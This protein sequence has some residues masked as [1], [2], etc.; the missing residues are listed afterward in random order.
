MFFTHLGCNYPFLQRERFMRDLEEKQVDSILVDAVCGVAARFSSDPMLTTAADDD[1]TPRE[2][3]SKD[4]QRAFR[5]HAYT[6]RAMSAIIDTFPCP[7]LAVAQACLLL[8]YEEFGTDHDSGLWM[9]L[10]TSIR[11]AQ[12]LGIQK[13]EGLQLQGRIGPTPK[14]V[15]SDQN[16][17]EE[18]YR[19]AEQQKSLSEDHALAGTKELEDRRASE[20]ERIDTFWA[21]FFL[22]RAVSSGVGRPVTLR[23]KDIEISFP[24]EPDETTIN[25]FPHPFPPM[26]RIVHMYGR[27]AD[28]LNH[29]KDLSQVTP[30]VLKKLAK[31]E[32]DLTT[33][34]QRLSPKLHFNATNFQHYVKAEQELSISSAKTIADILAFAEL[35]DVKSF[36]GNPFT[37]QPIEAERYA[38]PMHQT[39]ASPPLSPLDLQDLT[40]DE[41]TLPS[42]ASAAM[43][44][45]YDAELYAALLPD[46]YRER[47]NTLQDK[48]ADPEMKTRGILISHP[49][50]DYELL[51]ERLLESLELDA[52]R[53][54]N[55]HFLH[56]DRSVGD[57]GFES[58]SQEGDES[59]DESWK[60]GRCPDCGKCLHLQPEDAR[61]WEIKVYAANGLMRAGA[62]AA[63]W[64]DMEKVDVEISLAMPD[65]V[66]R[67]INSRLEILRSVQDG[68][69]GLSATSH[70]ENEINDEAN[71]DNHHSYEHTNPPPGPTEESGKSPGLGR[72]TD[73]FL[74]RKNLLIALL[75]ILVVFYA[76]T[77]SRSATSLAVPL[78]MTEPAARP[79]EPDIIT[80]TLV[81]NSVKPD[82]QGPVPAVVR[83]LPSTTTPLNSGNTGGAHGIQPREKTRAENGLQSEELDEELPEVPE[84]LSKE[85]EELAEELASEELPE[86]LPE[87]PE[88]PQSEGLLSEELPEEPQSERLLS[89]ELQQE[90]LRSES[91]HDN[92]SPLEKEKGTP[93][94][95]TALPVP[96]QASPNPRKRRASH[97]PKLDTLPPGSTVPPA[98]PSV[99]SASVA[100][101]A[102]LSEDSGKK[103][104]RTNTPWTAAEEQRLKQMRDKGHSWSEIAKAFP[105]R[106]EGSVKK[107]WYKVGGPGP[108]E[109]HGLTGVQDMHYAEFAEDE[110]QALRNAIREYD[111]NKWKAIGQKLGKPAKACEQYA[112]EHFKGLLRGI[113]RVEDDEKQQ[114]TWLAYLQV[115]VLWTSVNLA[116][117]NVTLG[118]LGPAVYELSFTDSSVCAS[119]GAILGALPVAWI[120][121][122][123]PVAGIR[124]MVLGR[125]AMGYWPSK[126]IA[127]L[128]IIVFLGY[129]L[130]VCIIGGQVLSAISPGGNMSVVVGIVILAVITWGV[131][132]FGIQVFHYYERY[133]FLP[134]LIVF[135][136]L[137]GVAAKQFDLHTPSVGDSA[138]V[139]GN[140]LSFFSLC[141]S[142][143]I[144][145]SGL[146]ADFF[147]Y[148]PATTSRKLVFAMTMA[149]LTFS[150]TFT[151]VLGAGLASGINTNPVYA[152]AWANSQGGSG[153]GALLVEAYADSLGT[154]GKFCAVVAALGGIANIVPSTYSAGIDFQLLGRYFLQVP[155]V[156]WNTVG[157]L[158]YTVCALVGRNHLSEIFTNFLALM[159]YWVVIWVAILL[160]EFLLFRRPSS[161]CI[162][163]G[164]RGRR[165]LT[166]DWTVWDDGHKLPVGMAASVAF[167]VGWAGAILCMA[168]VWYVGPIAK[169]VGDYG[170]DMGNYVGFSFAALVYPGLRWLE[171]RK[172]GR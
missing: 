58:G 136:I 15:K 2:A 20:Q 50:D 118:M 5:G 70:Q 139:A 115:L 107:H 72:H 8:A 89:D 156:V 39:S 168:Q 122:Y 172:W 16:G 46:E 99:P 133:A 86:E 90:R 53:I 26:I 43:P 134:Q 112:K 119:L 121:T 159:G 45:D 164:G 38:H 97:S 18:E 33:I 17:K 54:R 106:T 165:R 169:L 12:D 117:N 47:W 105:S 29:I 171:I 82:I 150:F 4:V 14:T 65:D 52:P 78:Q 37:S 68:D 94:N 79:I 141:L 10:G 64:R 62:W 3:D 114:I 144:T 149:G 32:K 109:F 111:A 83:I 22:D 41:L 103:K 60:T 131:T 158:I 120:A 21:I 56:D 13:L 34:Y 160:Q 138:T 81:L 95:S 28:V 126:L 162:Q 146:A 151:F 66:R 42:G 127:I 167:L 6:Q 9:Y 1:S 98:T 40:D 7:T 148:W 116:I 161:S 124:T 102:L 140:R 73:I 128:N 166:F 154:F 125:Y 130:V 30:D 57:S 104:G 113:R 11:M 155:R 19:R 67:E 101:P 157:V 84:E 59:I 100:I 27:V 96:P 44:T 23:D 88:E 135:S 61:K 49:Q 163:I 71:G 153:S 63:A 25:G 51:E 143:A 74:D 24:Y 110:S 76:I 92:M 152:N 48:L 80:S 123:G 108:G 142:A 75:S 36:I 129:S 87:L 77:G 170:A 91:E 147:V 55:S 137:Y 132:T 85:P 35:I 145:Y 69:D 93:T 31:M